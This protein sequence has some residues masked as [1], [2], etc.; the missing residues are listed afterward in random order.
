MLIEYFDYY[1]MSYDDFILENENSIRLL[2]VVNPE[3]KVVIT[4]KILRKILNFI[5]G[6]FSFIIKT[7]RSIN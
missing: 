5:I 6:A 7:K 3:I 2:K 4:N 1:D